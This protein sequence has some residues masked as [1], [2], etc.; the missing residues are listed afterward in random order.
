MLGILLMVPTSPAAPGGA[1]DYPI[2]PVAAGAVRLTDRFWAP[3]LETNRRVT[4]PHCLGQCEET[5]RIDNFAFAG[6]LRTGKFRG[7]YF[8]DS[9][10]YKLIEGAAYALA[11]AP[12]AALEARLDGVIEQI[13]AAQAPD[14]Y[15]YTARALC[16][17]DYMPPGGKERWSDIATG[18]EL[19][20]AGHLYEAGVAYAQATGKRKLLDV[21]RRNADLVCSV[22]GPGRDERPSGHPEIELALVRLYRA[23]G[24]E[25][26]LRQAQFFIAAR[27]RGERDRY[28]PY[29]QDHRPVAEQREAVGHAV[30]AAY[31]YCGA[32]DVAAAT[33][34][35]RLAA[36]VGDIWRDVVDSKLY[37][38]GGI[39]A[40]GAGEAFGERY[41]LPSRSAYAETCAAIAGAMWNE[42]LFLQSGDARYIDV[43]E[44]ILY[45]GFL[46]GVSLSGD[47]FFYV[48]PLE[49]P[50]GAERQPWFACACCPPNVVRFLETVPGLVY[51]TRGDAVFVN[52]FVA[53]AAEIST[54]GGPLRLRQETGYPFDGRVRLHVDP[55]EAAREFEMRLRIPGWSRGE[56]VPSKLYAYVGSADA[57][58]ALRVNGE[59][60]LAAADAGYAVIRRMWRRGDVIEWALPMA[61]RR[62]VA[63][64]DVRDCAD[65]VA[66]ERGP[67]VYCLEAA[68]NPDATLS[69]L[70]LDDDATLDAADSDALGG[71]SV[72]RGTARSAA[73]GDGG[74]VALTGDVREFTAIPYAL[75]ANRSRGAMQVWLARR[76]AAAR[77]A[78]AD[79]IARRASKSSSFGGELEA[80]ADQIEPRSS[81]DQESTRLHW[82]PRKGESVWVQYDFTAP[83][84]V[85]GVDVY[86]F[87]DTGVGECRVPKSCR[88][89][90]KVGGSWRDIA[91]SA[92]VGVSPDRYNRV[93]F[94]PL[95]ADGL[96]LEID[97]QPGWAGGI[98][99][100]HVE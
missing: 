90:A 65:R 33:G 36:A 73:R 9:D 18:H 71:I 4:I 59:E 97:S 54:T 42:R 26:Y 31:L 55:G 89:L 14:G 23:T 57:G 13:A 83:T 87:D 32:L 80:L 77:P 84:A 21:A 81:G 43:L 61:P 49:A 56:P 96:R 16:G 2:T 34:D 85:R 78:P 8:N 38:T 88:L 62:V 30:R 3:R 48:N 64:E 99:E 17:D 6:K 22:F 50:A 41:E 10:V 60:Q 25:G 35:A 82:W 91:G 74:Q 15:L 27:G 7:I 19:Y 24:A 86:W 1:A 63:R 92:A 44:R 100:W 93:E 94:A 95:T 75:W 46:S 11:A 51:A 70:V 28:G 72:I 52:L 53:S 5:G 69:A 76:L 40:R 79:T 98:H 37:L 12:D 20:C 67:L 58:R 47:R 39:G 45:N 66:L 29:A 68:D